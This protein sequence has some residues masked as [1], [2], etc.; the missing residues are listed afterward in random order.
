VEVVGAQAWR[1]KGLGRENGE[2]RT[3][4]GTT[5]FNSGSRLGLLIWW[6]VEALRG[7]FQAP[8]KFS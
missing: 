1:D 7:I 8:P 3:A 2:V 5:H 6:V 4:A